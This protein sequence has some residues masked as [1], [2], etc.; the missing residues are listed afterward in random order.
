MPKVDA[1]IIPF[2]RGYL[3]LHMMSNAYNN[4]LFKVWFKSFV[5]EGE[6]VDEPSSQVDALPTCSPTIKAHTQH[7]KEVRKIACNTSN[8]VRA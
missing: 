6:S 3:P 1:L 7:Q 4:P 8:L 2:D 5:D